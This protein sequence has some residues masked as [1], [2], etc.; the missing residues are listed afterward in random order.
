MLEAE[1]EAQRQAKEEE[2]RRSEI[3]AELAAERV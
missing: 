2:V 3:E 1:L